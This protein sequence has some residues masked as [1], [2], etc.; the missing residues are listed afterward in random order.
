VPDPPLKGV[1]ARL[2]TVT[3]PDSFVDS[4]KRFFKR[5]AIIGTAWTTAGVGVTQVLRLVSNIVLA[6]VLQ[7]EV[8]G[9]MTLVN[10]IIQG[11]LMF[12]DIGIGPNVV[13]NPRGDER[14]F[15]DTAWTIQIIRSTGLSLIALASAIPVANF[16]M[17]NDPSASEI[18]YLL[19]IV[20]LGT[21]MDGFQSTKVRTAARHM[22]RSRVVIADVV[23]QVISI[24]TMVG[25]ALWTRSVYA[26]A[27]GGV[28]GSISRVVLSNAMFVGPRNR[29]RWD[30]RAASE[31][32]RF[33]R[34]IFISTAISFLA[35]QVDKLSLGRLFPLAEVGVYSIAANLALLT[36]S[37]MGHVQGTI[38]FP[39]YSRMLELNM[40]VR[41]VVARTREPML[42][43]GGYLVALM[44]AGA[45]SFMSFAYDSRY[46]AAGTYVPI[47]AAGAWFAMLEGNYGAA[48]QATGRFHWG[49]IANAA[50]VLTFVALVW[51]LGRLWGLIG[52]VVV[53]ALSDVVRLVVTAIAVRQLDV[54]EYWL[55]FY[56]LALTMIVGVGTMT[57]VHFGPALLRELPLLALVLEFVV[58]TLAFAPAGLR[59][60]RQLRPSYGPAESSV[61]G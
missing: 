33:G 48:L 45:Q 42:V 12:S 22:L 14:D 57:A 30:P 5:K 18:R 43:A 17:K 38:A 61:A 55:E 35:A 56:C 3:S 39:L 27:I 6:A 7:E 16:Y 46:A 47:L 29:L 34:W 19:P 10:A 25:L 36:P 11:L 9:L 49:A 59:V 44:I 52:V 4:Q 32:I 23:T 13:Q 51:P 50:K 1:S 8:F 26:L 2:G 28:V 15:L 21:F 53:V 20:A 24:A 40:T 54:R 60:L 31:L 41:A 58:V 37:V